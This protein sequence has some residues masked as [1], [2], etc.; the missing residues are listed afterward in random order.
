MTATLTKPQSQSA[1]YQS[2]PASD[3]A[4]ILG[5]G[6]SA[7]RDL[8]AL[9]QGRADVLAV[10][11]SWRMAPFAALNYAS[12]WQY[13]HYNDDY[14][15]R[16]PRYGRCD[17]IVRPDVIQ[18]TLASHAGRMVTKIQTGP[19]LHLG[20]GMT[21]SY[22]AAN[23]AAQMGYKRIGLL[24]V[25]CSPGYSPHVDYW[26]ASMDSAAPELQALGI[27]IADCGQH[28]TLKAWPKLQLSEFLN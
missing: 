2:T 27:E 21:S 25:D 28:S 10:N 22:Q 6:P 9:A 12:D 18:I 5:T 7:S 11:K 24:G 1:S 8:I 26:R 16:G 4:I 19:P 20:F 14:G 3:A 17:P 15:Y 23:L 13:W